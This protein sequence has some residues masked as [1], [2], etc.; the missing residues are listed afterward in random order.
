MALGRAGEGRVGV[1]QKF[2][3]LNQSINWFQLATV[4]DVNG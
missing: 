4:W 2:D 3:F 1:T